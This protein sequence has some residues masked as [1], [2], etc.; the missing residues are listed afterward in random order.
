M[1]DRSHGAIGGG[2]MRA[3]AAVAAEGSSGGRARAWRVLALGFVTLL[4][5]LGTAW[6]ADA[7]VAHEKPSDR[8]RRIIGKVNDRDTR[9]VRGSLHALAIRDNDLGRVDASL[10]L[11]RVAIVFRPS[12]AQQQELELLLA[13]QRDPGS[14]SF[15][16]WLSPD[17]Y[18]ARF[19]MSDAD[20]DQVRAWLAAQGL[21]VQG[22]SRSR[23]E[24]YF[25]GR[26]AQI[27]SAFRTELHRYRAGDELHYANAT[28]P[29][30]PAA[31]GDVVLAIRKLS[32]FRPEPRLRRAFAAPRFTSEISGNHFLAPDDFATIYNV[33]PLWDAGWDGT[34]QRIAVIGQTA[35]GPG[36]S[37]ADIDAFRAASGLPATLLQQVLVPGS[38][39]STQCSGDILE[40]HLDVQWAGAVA[41]NATIVYVYTGV[42]SGRTC[43]TTEFNVWD[44]LQHAISNNLAPVIST[45]YG[46]C[47]AANGLGFAQTVRGWAQQANAQGQ[48]VTSASGDLGAADCEPRGTQSATTGLAVDVP[49]SIP[50]VTSVGGTRFVGDVAN[51][52]TY[53][54]ATNNASNGSALSYI[55][56]SGWDDSSVSILL[57]GGLS[58]SGG[59]ASRFFS[60]PSWQT[61]VG[62]PA[63]GR[64]DLPDVALNASVLHDPY[65]ICSQGSCVDGYRNTDLTLTVIGGTSAGAPAFA[66]IL[67]LINQGTG[68]SGLG[69]VN[70]K[71]YAL[72]ASL[73]A[74]FHD[75]TTGTNN[76]P[77]SPGTA[78]CPVIPPYQFG[79]TAGAGY[80]LVTGLGSVDAF[81]LADGWA[82][83]VAT[84]T[85]L[86]ASSP[87]VAPG[88]NATFTATVAALAAGTGSPA[89]ARVQFEL[90]GSP[91][92]APVTVVRSLNSYSASYATTALPGGMHSIGASFL[93]NLTHLGSSATPIPVNVAEY[94]LTANPASLLLS[95]GG[96]GTSILTVSSADG[97]VGTVNLTCTPPA[98]A[99]GVTCSASP[100]ALTLSVGVPS[101]TS[102]LTVTTTAPPAASAPVFGGTLL[103]AELLLG[104]P[105]ARRRRALSHL[106][107][108]LALAVIAASCGGGGGGGGGGASATSS[109]TPVGNYALTLNATSGSI[110]HPLTVS[111]AVQ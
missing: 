80:V 7:H 50:E 98:G 37:A 23:N 83:K 2:G 74:A 15:R 5:A 87:A 68:S 9:V 61:G 95:P 104:T 39:A 81:A 66:G 89:G 70:P 52:A 17:E 85:T 91:L 20:L 71:L 51:E 28:E 22:T 108:V 59:G 90:D 72:A 31:F 88:A 96:T 103:A 46:A 44:A 33:A 99:T 97:F 16:Q 19:G 78:N 8:P 56:E 63:D 24:L 12:V 35:L 106:L 10:V 102:T 109:A 84:S 111:L 105:A 101:Q 11:D 55:P 76:V 92:G 42:R 18:A 53:W 54:S 30:V 32:D 110:A 34:G 14:P 82:P 41:R 69:N 45:S 13:A 65:L 38:G 94:A 58:S 36:N 67:S 60:K 75:I 62:V 26:A 57:G 77:C 40:A 73:P 4:F 21:T 27:E 93:G 86:A 6:L 3:R 1:S 64:R 79:F 48:T 25:R 43:E 47:E 29:S 49:S 100:S 107:A